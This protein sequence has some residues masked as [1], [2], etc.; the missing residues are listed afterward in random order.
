M[1]NSNYSD[2][3]AKLEHYCAYQ[4]RCRSEV[5]TKLYK[6]KIPETIHHKL[7][8]ELIAQ[9]FI[10]ERRYAESFIRGKISLKKDGLQKIKFALAQ[11]GIDKLIIEQALAEQDQDLYRDNLNLLI[12]KKWELLRAKNDRTASHVK[13]CKYLL[14]KG[15]SY[16]DFKQQLTKLS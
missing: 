11:K 7:I 16:E 8:A 14:G 10:D 2:Y 13:L 15:Y 9:D 5:I 4:E 6:L 12:K 1:N 3:L